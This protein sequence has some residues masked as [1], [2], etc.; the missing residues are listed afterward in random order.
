MGDFSATPLD[1]LLANQQK[2]YTG[3][4]IEQGVPV[5]D[6][7]LNLLQDLVTAGIRALFTH[8]V[9][10]GLASGADGF[11]VEALPTGQ[12]CAGLPDH[13]R[14]ERFRVVP[15]R[16]HRGDDPRRDRLREPGRGR[17]ADH[18]SA[19]PARPAGRHRVPRCLPRGGGRHHGSGPD[20]Q[21]GRRHGDL[22]ATPARLGGPGGRG[23]A[24]TAAARRARVLP[25]GRAEPL[26]RRRHYRPVDDHRPAAAPPD[27]VGPGTA[28]QP[29]G[30][31]AAAA[32][33]S[34]PRN[35]LCTAEASASWSP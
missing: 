10:N 19:Q 30:A 34:A 17:P 20:E 22:G 7:D 6:R 24:G 21:P 23:R 1:F 31:G 35:S 25:P 32:R 16:R 27:H 14:S 15:G 18:A 13:R 11:G 4:H 3:L 5:L 26:A 2:G 9:G 8:Y 28:A 12:N 33:R 29:A